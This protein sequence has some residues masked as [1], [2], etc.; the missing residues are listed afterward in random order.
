MEGVI[1]KSL[2]WQEQDVVVLFAQLCTIGIL[3]KY[4]LLRSFEGNWTY[5]AIFNYEHENDE[6]YRYS[7]ENRLGVPERNLIRAPLRGDPGYL[8]SNSIYLMS[9]MNSLMEKTIR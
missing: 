4:S 1:S 7:D 8:S 5:D 9:L 2:P 6:S 3:K